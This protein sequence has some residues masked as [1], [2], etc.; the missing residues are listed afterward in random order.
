LALEIAPV[1][2]SSREQ[3]PHSRCEQ[4]LTTCKLANQ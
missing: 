3:V 4:L 2:G 1:E